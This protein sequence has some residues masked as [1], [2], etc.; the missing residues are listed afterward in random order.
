MTRWKSSN[1]QSAADFSSV[2]EE[3][4]HGADALVAAHLRLSMNFGPSAGRAQVVREAPSV[5]PQ[6]ACK[7]DRGGLVHDPLPHEAIVED[8]V[9]LPEAS[10]LLRRGARSRP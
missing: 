5:E 6:L 9:H 1:R 10:L 2:D 4:R 3:R 7:R 8:V